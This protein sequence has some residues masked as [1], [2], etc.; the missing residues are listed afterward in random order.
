MLNQFISNFSI[1]ARNP[2][3]MKQ[4]DKEKESGWR[5]KEGEREGENNINIDWYAAN[6]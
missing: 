3:E 6:H 4:R 1:H 5:E 2:D